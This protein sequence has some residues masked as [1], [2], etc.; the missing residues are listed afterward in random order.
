MEALN[1]VLNLGDKTSIKAKVNQVLHRGHQLALE[2]I[3]KSA[4]LAS[5]GCFSVF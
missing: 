4:S 5:F 2:T 1:D 3:T